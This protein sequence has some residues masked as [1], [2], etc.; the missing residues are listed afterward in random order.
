MENNLVQLVTVKELLPI[1]TLKTN[2]EA[3]AIQLLKC[4]EHD[5]D[6]I[7]GK[8]LYNIGDKLLYILPDSNLKPGHDYLSQ[9]INPTN[10]DG[11]TISSKLGKNNR[12]KA[13]GFNFHKGD[14]NKLYSNGIVCPN[15]LTVVDFVY[16]HQEAEE[17]NKLTVG[18]RKPFPSFLYKTDETNYK[19]VA[20][21]IDYP[22]T[23]VGTVKDDGSSI[24]LYNKN[25]TFGICSRNLEKPLLIDKQI[26]VKN[27]LPDFI[28]RLLP[29][30]IR[31]H[32]WKPI[33]Q[34]VT[35][36]DDFVKYGSKYMDLLMSSYNNVALRGELVGKTSLGSGNKANPSKDLETQIHFYGLD[37]IVAGRAE[38]AP[39]EAFYALKEKGFPIVEVLFNKIFNSKEELENECLSIFNEKFIEGIVLRT[40]DSKFSCKFMND[41]YDTLK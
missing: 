15:D 8:G 35:N 32:F 28:L 19:I 34:T 13:I 20:N 38:K 29:H 3:N 7:V 4:E 14:F 26:G 30:K 37:Y 16:K 31:K 17:N 36:N 40:L 18:G 6:I 21:S 25:M 39:F 33:Y 23:F 41:K 9:Y 2:E 11:Q 27:Y 24:T 22:V 5:F 12:V 1:F 10:K